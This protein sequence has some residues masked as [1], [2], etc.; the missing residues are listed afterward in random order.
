M[1]EVQQMSDLAVWLILE[2]M[3][4]NPG[5]QQTLR[6][7]C[8]TV[9]ALG[10][11]GGGSDCKRVMTHSSSPSLHPHIEKG[12]RTVASSMEHKGQT[13]KGE[14]LISLCLYRRQRFVLRLFVQPLG[15]SSTITVSL[16][17]PRFHIPTALLSHCPSCSAI[18]GDWWG[19]GGGG[20]QGVKALA[21]QL[22]P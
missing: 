20:G 4:K 3:T 16:A 17:A 10:A 8:N 12:A 18:V 5:T 13:G 14:Q 6:E 2:Q 22:C 7:S 1:P 15:P 9:E 19:A 21:S 11:D